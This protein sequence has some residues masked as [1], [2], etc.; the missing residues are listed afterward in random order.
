MRAV[1]KYYS[2]AECALLLSCSEK[3][4]LRKLKAGDFG[5]EVVNLGSAEGADY[6]VPA[7][8][9][10]EYLRGRRVFSESMEPGVDARS[11]GELR[12]KV[13]V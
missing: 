6:R 3:T 8:G 11:V 5:K 7:S 9:L 4:I 1:E 10:N 2:V 12:R 13:K